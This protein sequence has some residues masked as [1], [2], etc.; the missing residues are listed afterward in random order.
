MEMLGE[1]MWDL[2]S[3]LKAIFSLGDGNFKLL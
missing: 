3:K 2:I 1:G